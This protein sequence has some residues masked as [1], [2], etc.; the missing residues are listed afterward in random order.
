MPVLLDGMAELSRVRPTNPVEWL[1]T[2]MLK[3][4]PQNLSSSVA[5]RK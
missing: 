3:N 4:N 2:Y 1:A 5:E